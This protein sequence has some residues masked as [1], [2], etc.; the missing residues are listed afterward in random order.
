VRKI[1]I[2]LDVSELVALNTLAKL[3]RRD[4]RAQAAQIIRAELER[5]GLLPVIG[6]APTQRDAAQQMGAAQNATA[7]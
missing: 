6:D 5:H 2:A 7:G 4:S 3:K 1:L